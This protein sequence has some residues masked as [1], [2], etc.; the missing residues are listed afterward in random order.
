M[1]PLDTIIDWFTYPDKQATPRLF[2]VNGLAGT[3]KTRL[4]HEVQQALMD[5][6][7][8]S[9]ISCAPTGKAAQVLTERG[10]PT[11]TIHRLIYRPKQ[12]T[13]AKLQKLK[14]EYRECDSV[15]ERQQLEK[16]IQ[17]EEENLRRP[18]FSLNLD[19]E[20]KDHSLVILDEAPMVADWI[21]DDLLSF[22]NVRLLAFGDP[23]QLRPVKG[24]AFFGLQHQ[25]NLTL[26]KI[27]RQAEGNPIV[28]MA[29]TIYNGG[30]LSQGTYGRSRVIHK[31]QLDAMDVMEHSQLLVGKNNTRQFFN[32]RWREHQFKT[33]D[34]APMAG[35]R[36]IVLKN[37]YNYNVMNGEV[38]IIQ[39]VL[40]SINNGKDYEVKL[41]TP[42]GVMKASIY[43]DYFRNEKPMWYDNDENYLHIDYAY[44]ITTHKAQ[45]SQWPSIY[46]YDESYCFRNEAKNWLYTAITR[47]QDYVTIAVG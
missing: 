23:G 30:Y 36:V 19:S 17:D 13:I 35:D 3:G 26:D 46:V 10:T 31:S 7:Y 20:I 42:Y 12:K 40:T 25:P 1:K 24:T 38:F 21:V 27:W 43:G 5:Q 9:S 16:Y 34:P 44:A 14:E 47:A 37:N 29:H 32:S 18:A 45:G 41:N 15:V 11:K 33:K 8:V 6:H 4:A 28:D 22:S 39:E 2:F